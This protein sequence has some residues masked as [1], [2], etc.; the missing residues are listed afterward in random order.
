MVP[1]QPSSSD[2]VEAIK[3]V[4]L[5]ESASQMVR[6]E[7]PVRVIFTDY[8]P[9]TN[10]AQHVESEAGKYGLPI[11]NV[12]LNRLVAFKEMTFT[13]VV[14]NHDTAGAQVSRLLR[15]LQALG[16]LPFMK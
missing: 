13:G 11:M 4:K 1:V 6:Q 14:P 2:V 8:Q 12:R 16:V 15:E 9:N 10:V 5:V 7:I 3:T